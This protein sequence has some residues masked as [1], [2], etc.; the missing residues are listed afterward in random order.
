MF[1]DNKYQR[2]FV[3]I[4][5]DQQFPQEW[6]LVLIHNNMVVIFEIYN[7]NPT[8]NAIG[9]FSFDFVFDNNDITYIEE[10]IV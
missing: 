10:I 6:H 2:Y 5:R 9:S 3:T 1:S 8:L 7:T 4:V